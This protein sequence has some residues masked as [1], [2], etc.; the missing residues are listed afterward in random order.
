VIGFVAASLVAVPVS[1]LILATALVLGPFTGVPVALIGSILS[2]L[3]GY[4]IGAHTGRSA[5]ERLSGG[6]LDRLS[7]RLAE[8]GILTIITL[9]IVP[10]APF[11]VLN[12]FAGASHLRLRDF[13]I[14]TLIGMAP[15][16][17]TMAVFAEGLLSLL[18]QAGLR[19]VALLLVGLLALGGLAWLS[20]RWLRTDA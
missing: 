14:G 2:A 12:L 18:W 3:A 6:R 11:A 8:H 7:R 17:I 5:V 13:V 19:A 15:A 16:V 10:V 1:F 20:R 4:G 9:R